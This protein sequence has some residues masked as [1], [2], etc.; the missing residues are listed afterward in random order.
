MKLTDALFEG[1]RNFYYKQILCYFGYL[2]PF[3]YQFILLDHISD[4]ASKNYYDDSQEPAIIICNLICMVIAFGFF[5]IEIIQA[6]V[7]GFREYLADNRSYEI[8]WFSVQ[9]IY[10]LMKVSYPST[11][12]PLI[13]YVDS[14]TLAGHKQSARVMIIFSFLNSILLVLIGLKLFYFLTVVSSFGTMIQ[15]V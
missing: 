11:S 5:L 1:S 13:D 4:D 9:V 14:A 3:F 10:F 12:F 15:L 2:I 7:L 8:I 6:R